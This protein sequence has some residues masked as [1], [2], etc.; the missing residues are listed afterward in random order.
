LIPSWL[1]ATARRFR[2]PLLVCAG[3]AGVGALALL[4]GGGEQDDEFPPPPPTRPLPAIDNLKACPAEGPLDFTHYWVGEE[5]DG[6]PLQ[7]IYHLCN[8]RSRNV[9]A[10]AG[11][12]ENVVT[13]VYSECSGE[14]LEPCTAAFQIES[15]PACE[16]TLKRKRDLGLA[17]PDRPRFRVRGAPVF[18]DRQGLGGF[19]LYAGDAWVLIVDGERSMEIRLARAI[20]TGPPNLS[21]RLNDNRVGSGLPELREALA[22]PSAQSGPDYIG[23][24]EPLPPPI[25]GAVRGRPVC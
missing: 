10:P 8:G 5:F 14:G 4:Y 22:D 21:L 1:E 17:Y 15:F 6:V 11:L 24:G 16:E 12:R 7:T 13:Y 2:V 19:G 3:I 9:D 20:R 23:P 25:P 18:L